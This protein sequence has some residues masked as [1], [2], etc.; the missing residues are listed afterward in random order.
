MGPAWPP[1]PKRSPHPDPLSECAV[2]PGKQELGLWVVRVAHRLAL[3]GEANYPDRPNAITRV[4]T[5]EGHTQGQ[6]LEKHS[7]SLHWL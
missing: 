1:S 2:L 3:D 6:H 4:L 7:A 5:W